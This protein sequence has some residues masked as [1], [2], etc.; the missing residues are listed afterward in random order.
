MLRL[1]PLSLCNPLQKVHKPLRQGTDNQTPLW[2]RHEPPEWGHPVVHIF[3]PI[4]EIPSLLKMSPR[5]TFRCILPNL[6]RPSLYK[7]WAVLYGLFGYNNAW[8]VVVVCDNSR[9]HS[10]ASLVPLLD[11]LSCAEYDNVKQTTVGQRMGEEW[12]E[13][14]EREIWYLFWCRSTLFKENDA[15]SRRIALYYS[16]T[17]I[18]VDISWW[19][20]SNNYLFFD[21]FLV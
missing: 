11:Y 14:R 2:A 8:M 5:D 20:I 7:V 13:R 16:S 4:E 1:L 15:L 17:D 9:L 10:P 12:P 6:I 21:Y 18:V 19:L 3:T